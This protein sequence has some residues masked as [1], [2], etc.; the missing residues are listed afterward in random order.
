MKSC[1]SA[2]FPETNFDILESIAESINLTFMGLMVSLDGCF[3]SKNLLDQWE[4]DFCLGK[5]EKIRNHYRQNYPDI[6]SLDPVT[7][8][9]CLKLKTLDLIFSREI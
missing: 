2:F 7:I 3:Q 1:L 5:S 6:E 8:E 4:R 9:V